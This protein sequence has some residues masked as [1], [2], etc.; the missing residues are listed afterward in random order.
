MADSFVLGLSSGT[1]CL[2]TCGMIMFPYLMA[3]SAGIKQIAFDLAVF[4]LTRLIVYFVLATIA[5]YF[6]QAFFTTVI[7]RN[8][9]P[10][11]LYI[12]FAALLIWYS[13]DKNHK[14]DCPA[15]IVKTVDNRKLV[16]VLLGIVNSIGFCPAL[17]IILTKGATQHTLAQSYIAFLAFFAGSSLWF[18]PLPFAGMVKRR[19]V[20]QIIGTFAT[21]IAGM[22]FI[23]KGITMLIGGIIN[24]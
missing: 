13:I 18:V 6:G 16:P 19:Q 10:G 17:L 9:L 15:A 22:I 4:L 5:W 7:L 21:G 2:V 14:R 23:I 24:G 8:Y 12:I 3:G 20:L 11:V 1:A